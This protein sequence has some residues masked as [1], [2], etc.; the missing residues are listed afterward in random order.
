ML[1]GLLLRISLRADRVVK[2]DDTPGTD[3]GSYELGDFAIE[4]RA[5]RIVVFPVAELR[6]ECP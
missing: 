3:L 1:G 6:A 2:D 4:V 5:D